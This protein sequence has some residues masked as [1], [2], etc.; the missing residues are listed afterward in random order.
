V[1][2]RREYPTD[3][4]NWYARANASTLPL[5][6]TR[7]LTEIEALMGLA[8]HE[9]ADTPSLLETMALK[10]A[11]GAAIDA[12]EPEDKWIF[13]ALFVEQLSLR[14]AGHILGIPKTS[15]AR[16]RDYIRRQ[17]MAN[18]SESPAVVQWLREGLGLRAFHTLPEHPHE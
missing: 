13:N 15:L 4:N 10:E 12:L 7:P 3:P 16:R 2:T 11:V 1:A 8:P 17:L 14:A 18:L 9:N 5:A 6:R